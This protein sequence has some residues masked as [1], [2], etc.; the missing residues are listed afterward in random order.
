MDTMSSGGVKSNGAH[1]RKVENMEEFSGQITERTKRPSLA[2]PSFASSSS[3]FAA[4][5]SS[6]F[7]S[8]KG[9]ERAFMSIVPIIY[10]SRKKV[11]VNELEDQLDPF[12]ALVQQARETDKILL[13][14]MEDLY[15]V[16]DL[17]RL[18]PNKLQDSFHFVNGKLSLI[19]RN[20]H[21][22][23]YNAIMKALNEENSSRGLHIYGPSGLGKSYS[24]YYLVS[25]LRLQH[26]YRVTYINNCEE[27]WSS[28]QI[29]PY[30]YL[31]NEFLC[32]F[33]KD[34]LTPLTITDWVELVMYGLTNNVRNKL[35]D[36]SLLHNSRVN[37]IIEHLKQPETNTRKERFHLCLKE[38]V[39]FVKNDYYWIW[40]FDQCNSLYKYEVLNE[41]PFVL[42]NGLSGIL[43]NDGLIIVSETSNND[44]CLFKSWDKLGLF[45][46]YDD[47]EFNQWC[48]LR[49]YNDMAQLDYVKYWTGAYPSELDKWHETPAGNLQE[50]T[51]NYLGLR[52]SEIKRDYQI[53]RDNLSYERV[54][55]LNAC[56][57]SMILQIEPPASKIYDMD[58]R[59]MRVGSVSF[60]DENEEFE[61]ETVLAIHPCAR[62]TI[63]RAHGQID[64]LIDDAASKALQ[65]V[66][67]TIYALERISASY[68]TTLLD[69]VRTFEFT[70]WQFGIPSLNIFDKNVNFDEVIRIVDNDIFSIKDFNEYNNVLFIPE[71]T[72]Y[73][74]M[75]FLIWDCEDKILLVFQIAMDKI[76]ERKVMNYFDKEGWANLCDIDESK[77]YFNWIAFDNVIDKVTETSM[78][79]SNNK[80]HV[81]F[82]SIDD[83]FPAFKS[84]S[85]YDMIVDN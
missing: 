38:L 64:D 37:R 40:V 76:D 35:C 31:L 27:W 9:K 81:S 4:A 71:Y 30:Q 29:E 54:E 2:G 39:N 58:H 46:G 66:E 51:E 77:I 25:E 10:P 50:K 15:D 14:I 73:P 59:F 63:A 33:N 13:E 74:G 6:S 3:S 61:T 16:V 36:K 83:Q 52:E 1:K 72:K 44:V 75:D 82:S 11:K 70:C 22:Q 12:V 26:D 42:V 80:L 23:I 49:G 34:E 43:K 5:S 21:D 84:I 7:L 57:V 32:T 45:D 79:S 47:D 78:L 56:V 69:T 67:Y 41:Y 20:H 28:H 8:T 17:P 60:L 18:S 65:N 19:R 48:K 55:N 85:G 24:L 68:I 62:L 53:Y